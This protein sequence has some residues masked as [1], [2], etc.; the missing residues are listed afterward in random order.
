MQLRE[1]SP[2]QCSRKPER[3]LQSIKWRCKAGGGL[4]VQTLSKI[5]AGDILDFDISAMIPDPYELFDFER[6]SDK[7]FLVVTTWIVVFIFLL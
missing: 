6:G 7:L 4:S 1:H 3:C 2:L 5:Q